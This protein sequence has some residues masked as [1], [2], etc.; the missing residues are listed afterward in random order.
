MDASFDS[1][2]E[3]F[4]REFPIFGKVR[5]IPYDAIDKVLPGVAVHLASSIDINKEKLGRYLMKHA[6]ILKYYRVEDTQCTFNWI[7]L[8]T[9]THY[10][11]SKKSRGTGSEIMA[12]DAREQKI[13]H[14]GSLCSSRSLTPKTQKLV[15][16]HQP[17]TA[18]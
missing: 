4:A 12:T 15:F 17:T 10:K 8:D 9:A 16:W 6:G 3:R 7:V 1:F 18:Q 2:I 5:F 13:F 11:K 14:A